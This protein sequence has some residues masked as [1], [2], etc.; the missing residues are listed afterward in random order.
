VKQASKRIRH[1]R[2]SGACAGTR[3]RQPA[4][5]RYDSAYL[6]GAICPAWGK[7]AALALA[8]GG[9][10]MPRQSSIAPAGAPRPH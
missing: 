5:Q 7:G 4:D 2:P 9:A 10:R 1:L 8:Y 6:F 3:P